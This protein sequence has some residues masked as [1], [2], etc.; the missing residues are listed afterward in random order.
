MQVF[1]TLIRKVSKI[2]M[3]KHATNEIEFSLLL[4]LGVKHK[5]VSYEH[6]IQIKKESSTKK[7]IYALSYKY[8]EVNFGE[9]RKNGS[10]R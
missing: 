8:F 3:Y 6:S 10:D 2:H 4:S 1:K 7:N 5:S 9:V